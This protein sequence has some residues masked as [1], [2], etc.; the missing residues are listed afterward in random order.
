MLNNTLLHFLTE[1]QKHCSHALDVVAIAK[2]SGGKPN[3]CLANAYKNAAIEG[4]AVVSGW[5]V[6]PYD[7]VNNSRQ[8]TQHWWNY[9]VRLRQYLDFSPNIEV[10]ANYIVDQDI[11]YFAAVNNTSISSCVPYS[12][13]LSNG[14]FFGVRL[15]EGGHAIAPI[16]DLSTEALFAPYALSA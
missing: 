8:F 9:D 1:R 10:D 6:H 5:L 13:I 3:E 2:C 14:A 7:P 12:V 4:I 11:A 15:T 16:P